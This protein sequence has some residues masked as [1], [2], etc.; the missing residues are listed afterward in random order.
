M[1]KEFYKGNPYKEHIVRAAIR[2]EGDGM[3]YSMPRPNRHPNIIALLVK[4][5]S[6]KPIKGAQGFVTSTGRFVDRKEAALIAKE[7][8]QVTKLIAEPNLYSEDLW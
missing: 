1:T 6:R 3:V 2:H 7:A 5:G 4:M 8:G